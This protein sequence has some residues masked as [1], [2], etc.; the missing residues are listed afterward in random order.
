MF[1]ALV[2][3]RPDLFDAYQSVHGDQATATLRQ[4]RVF[5]SF[6]PLPTERMLFV[7]LFR[8]L[9]IVDRPT[10]EIYGDP[11]FSELEMNYGATDTAPQRIIVSRE[12]QAQFASEPMQQLEELRGRLQIATPVGRTYVRRAENL[13]ATVT[14][15]TDQPLTSPPPPDWRAFI[16]SSAELAVLPQ[17]WQALLRVWRGIY[18]LTDVDG[19][20]Y[21]GAAYGEENFLRRWRDHIRGEYGITAGL[22]ARDPSGFRFSILELVAPTAGIED[23]LPL[24]TSWKDRLHTRT[25]GLNVN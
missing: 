10:L 5:A 19:A 1:P 12:R 4:R 14:A 16:V 7:G 18:L 8:I 15:I 11:R 2:F 21:V 25:F 17:T 22:A 9:K 13:V 6:I 3:E 23:V 24:E 20:R